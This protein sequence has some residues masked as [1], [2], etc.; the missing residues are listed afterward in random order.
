MWLVAMWDAANGMCV[1]RS[2][3]V[4]CRVA[5]GSWLVSVVCS[6]G[7]VSV[8]S[9]RALLCAKKIPDKNTNT[10]K[11]KN[12][13]E[14]KSRLNYY[15]NLFYN[16]PSGLRSGSRRAC[17]LAAQHMHMVRGSM[18]GTRTIHAF[19]RLDLSKA[20]CVKHGKI[21]TSCSS[22]AAGC[23]VLPCKRNALATRLSS[24]NL[25]LVDLGIANLRQRLS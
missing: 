14:K 1:C 16:Y 10:N 12:K 21:S 20:S 9:N 6:R 5:C 4:W 17:D 7:S 19:R 13:K 24:G 18:Y 8:T 15:I 11:N 2:V 3:C 22:N 25:K 23:A